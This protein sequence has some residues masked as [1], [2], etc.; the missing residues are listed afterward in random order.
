MRRTYGRQTLV[1]GAEHMPLG[2]AERGGSVEDNTRDIGMMLL[3]FQETAI[4]KLPQVQL[5]AMPWTVGYCG[6]NPSRVVGGLLSV[7]RR[8]NDPQ[9]SL[10]Q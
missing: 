3:G 6:V 10:E 4:A 9:I 1:L 2:T 5:V 8:R 7:F